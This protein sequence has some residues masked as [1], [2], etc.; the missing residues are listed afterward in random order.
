ML[1]KDF[2]GNQML[3]ELVEGS[4]IRMVVRGLVPNQWVNTIGDTVKN[5][6]Q[7]KT[8]CLCPVCVQGGFYEPIPKTGGL[9]KKGHSITSEHLTEGHPLVPEVASSNSLWSPIFGSQFFNAGKWEKVTRDFIKL[10]FADLFQARKAET[11]R[12]H[13]L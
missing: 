6:T 11:H 3:L 9:C 13:S 4:Q 5:L 2:F 7:Q 12:T 1:L 10:Q 8:S